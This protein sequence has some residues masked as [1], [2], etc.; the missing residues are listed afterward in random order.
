LPVDDKE[1]EEDREHIDRGEDE[2]YR[3][4]IVSI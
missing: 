3:N 4:V 2:L 1:G